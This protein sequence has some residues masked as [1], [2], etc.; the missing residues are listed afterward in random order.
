MHASSLSEWEKNRSSCQSST[1][2]PNTKGWC[3]F[4]AETVNQRLYHQHLTRHELLTP[5]FRSIFLPS[6]KL[7]SPKFCISDPFSWILKYL[8]APLSYYTTVLWELHFTAFQPTL[9]FFLFFF[10]SLL[11]IPASYIYY[12]G[13]KSQPCCWQWVGDVVA[14]STL[15]WGRTSLCEFIIIHFIRFNDYEHNWFL[16]VHTYAICA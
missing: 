2:A 3:C 4:S 1:A 12:E 14:V 13:M 9:F 8:T 5:V 16:P 11:T 10:F 6:C 15:L 7:D